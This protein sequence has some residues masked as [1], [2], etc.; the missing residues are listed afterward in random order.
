MRVLYTYLAQ[1]MLK[2][3]V[4]LPPN[5]W[6]GMVAELYTVSLELHFYAICQLLSF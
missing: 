2:N 4:A 1:H 5:G 6:F 3:E